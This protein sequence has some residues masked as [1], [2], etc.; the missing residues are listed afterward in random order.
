MLA[1]AKVLLPTIQTETPVLIT[2]M[3]IGMTTATTIWMNLPETTVT[4][5]TI[6]RSPA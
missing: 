6:G 4:K 3:T 5:T 1:L 2:A